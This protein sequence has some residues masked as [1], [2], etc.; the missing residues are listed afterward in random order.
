MSEAICK[1]EDGEDEFSLGGSPFLHPGL[2]SKILD[3]SG[4]RRGCRQVFYSLGRIWIAAPAMPN[5]K[6][7]LP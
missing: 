4:V 5:K 2:E 7:E 1:F 6:L 3:L